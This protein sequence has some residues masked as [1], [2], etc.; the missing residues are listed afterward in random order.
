MHVFCMGMSVQREVC[1]ET[2]QSEHVGVSGS[3]E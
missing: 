3:H 2:V 1:K